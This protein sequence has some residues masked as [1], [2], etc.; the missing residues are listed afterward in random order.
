LLF[1]D[2][3]ENFI[4][5]NPAGEKIFGIS[6]GNLVGRNLADFVD[7]EQMKFIRSETQERILGKRSTYELE[8]KHPNG[9]RRSIHLTG[10]SQFDNNGGFVGTFGVFHDITEQKQIEQVREK[11]RKRHCVPV[12]NIFVKSLR[13]S[14][15]SSLL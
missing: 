10:N 1:V 12:K 15:T 4:F 2:S 8:I 5:A 13:M 9:E 11:K 6:P 7:A 14:P 3:K